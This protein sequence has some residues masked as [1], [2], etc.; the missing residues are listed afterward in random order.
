M[1][2]APWA[3]A[4][5]HGDCPCHLP[6][7]EE[8]L[9]GGNPAAHPEPWQRESREGHQQEDSLVSVDPAHQPD[10]VPAAPPPALLV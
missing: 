7:F 10:D 9:E 5:E 8:K 6:L 1:S 3:A 2:N 4:L